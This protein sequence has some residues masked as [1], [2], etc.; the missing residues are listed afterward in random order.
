MIVWFSINKEVDIINVIATEKSDFY[1][2]SNS[3]Q[4]REESKFWFQK[5][6]MTKYLF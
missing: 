3:T 5:T 4:I 6:S 2:E 1:G